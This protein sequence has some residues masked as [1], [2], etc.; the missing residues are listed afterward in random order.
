MAFL[1]FTP[2]QKVVQYFG[3]RAEVA[4]VKSFEQG[5][6]S[7]QF[8]GDHGVYQAVAMAFQNGTKPGAGTEVL[9]RGW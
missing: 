3:K 9:N 6:V 5:V 8:A 4:T 2:G 7:Y 1:T